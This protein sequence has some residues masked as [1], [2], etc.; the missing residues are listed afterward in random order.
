MWWDHTSAG[1]GR[2]WRVQGVR[3][4]G[5]SGEPL[6]PRRG[7][8]AVGFAPRTSRMGPTDLPKSRQKIISGGRGQGQTH[9]LV[10]GAC[11][12]DR[13]PGDTGWR[14]GRAAASGQAGSHRRPRPDSRAQTLGTARD[15]RLA[16]TLGRRAH[17]RHPALGLP[18]LFPPLPPRPLAH[19]GFVAT[20]G[21]SSGKTHR[22][23]SPRTGGGPCFLCHQAAIW[24]AMKKTERPCTS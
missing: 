17:R 21:S 12:G 9:V 15:P 2:I 1:D 3:G 16:G 6:G 20:P 7:W 22:P 10:W 19:I 18:G 13:V 5:G 4:V 24:E 14:D 11:P 8:A 23:Q